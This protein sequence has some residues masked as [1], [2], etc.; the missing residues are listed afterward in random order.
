LKVLVVVM[1]NFLEVEDD[2]EG[3]VMEDYGVFC[4]GCGG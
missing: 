1:M 4:G 3:L 2:N